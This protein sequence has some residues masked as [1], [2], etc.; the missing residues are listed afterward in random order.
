LAH[1]IDVTAIMQSITP[2]LESILPAFPMS[3]AASIV[4][5]AGV[6]A[7]CLHTVFRDVPLG[8]GIGMMHR[9]HVPPPPP[10]SAGPGRCQPA[11]RPDCVRGWQPRPTVWPENPPSP[12]PSF[13]K[14]TE[15]RPLPSRE[16]GEEAKT[17]RSMDWPEDR[18]QPSGND[19][20]HA[21]RSGPRRSAWETPWARVPWFAEH[22]GATTLCVLWLG[23]NPRCISS[24]LRFGPRVWPS[25]VVVRPWR[26]SQTTAPGCFP[27]LVNVSSLVVQLAMGN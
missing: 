9:T 14:A 13:A 21:L 3:P 8:Q 7:V 27:N 23:W 16:R 1:D 15:G 20:L 4:G 25:G 26:A 17:T 22:S 10:L 18:V 5:C 2:S 6:V 11:D 24:E 19:R 12:Y